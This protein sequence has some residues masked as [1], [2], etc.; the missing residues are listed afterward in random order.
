MAGQGR[1]SLNVA[2]RPALE[3]ATRL[4]EALGSVE[5]RVVRH[6]L[7]EV[8]ERIDLFLEPVRGPK[9]T[10]SSLARGVVRFREGSQLIAPASRNEQLGNFVLAFTAA[11]LG[12][13]QF[14]CRRSPAVERAVEFVRDFLTPEPR[15]SRIV[16]PEGERSGR[17]KLT[18]DTCVVD[19]ELFLIRGVLRIPLTDEPEVFGFGVWVSQKQENFE[20]YLANF[21]SAKIGPFFGWLCTSIRYYEGGTQHLK[22][23]AHF[24]GGNLRP[25]IQLEPSDHPLAVDQ[26][27]G[28]TLA[29]AWEIVHFYGMK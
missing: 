21:D 29:K 11:D 3:R 9:I 27:E 14:D 22:T 10:R 18:T 1:T 20:R 17:I 4:Q 16:I 13:E 24:Q 5:A 7:G 26:R 25:L 12:P 6:A 15:H 23:M 8:V 28:I 2:S 19:D